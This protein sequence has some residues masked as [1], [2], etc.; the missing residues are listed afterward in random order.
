M[1]LFCL[2]FTFGFILTAMLPVVRFIWR[3]V[4]AVW[5]YAVLVGLVVCFL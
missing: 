5:P 2:L 1:E 3:F 4:Y